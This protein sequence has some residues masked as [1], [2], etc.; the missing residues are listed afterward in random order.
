MGT[1]RPRRDETPTLVLGVRLNRREREVLER[2]RAARRGTR[3]HLVREAIARGVAAILED[4]S[5][6]GAVRV[7]LT[8][9]QVESLRRFAR[10]RPLADV[11]RRAVQ[12]GLVEMRAT[13]R[14]T[15]GAFR[16]KKKRRRLPGA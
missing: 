3:S 5:H 13:E 2:L 16:G 4:E 6:P 8:A 1:G 7:P 10:G 11:A 12:Q 14:R 9:R 15:R